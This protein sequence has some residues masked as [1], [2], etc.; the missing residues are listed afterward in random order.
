M[1]LEVSVR[2]FGTAVVV[3]FGFEKI[4]KGRSVPENG[5]LFGFGKKVVRFGN[6]V[7]N[8]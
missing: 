8:K 5:L 2:L 4:K 1:F 3:V 7:S 6:H